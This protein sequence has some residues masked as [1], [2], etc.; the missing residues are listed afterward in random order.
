MLCSIPGSRGEGSGLLSNHQ[1]TK[2]IITQSPPKRSG[3]PLIGKT[4]NIECLGKASYTRG[5]KTAEVEGLWLRWRPS[6]VCLNTQ[7]NPSSSWTPSFIVPSLLCTSHSCD[8]IKWC[9]DSLLHHF[10][11]KTTAHAQM[12]CWQLSAYPL[13]STPINHF[14]QKYVMSSFHFRTRFCACDIYIYNLYDYKWH[15]V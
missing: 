10:G 9:H 14:N 1:I 4:S 5:T 12:I 11:R 2:V 13:A 7:M 3:H 6:S 15:F 8:I